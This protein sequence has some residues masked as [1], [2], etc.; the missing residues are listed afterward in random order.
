MEAVLTTAVCPRCRELREAGRP[1]PLEPTG[2]SLSHALD[3][4]CESGRNAADLGGKLST[5]EDTEDAEEH[6]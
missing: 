4:W 5:T 3:E 2:A 1:A 6:T